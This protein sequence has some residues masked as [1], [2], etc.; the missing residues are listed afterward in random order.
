MAKILSES[1]KE[2]IDLKDSALR[3][4]PPMVDPVGELEGIHRSEG[5]VDFVYGKAGEK[6]RRAG[7]N[8]S[9]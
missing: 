1:W 3:G 7:R 9:I 4:A 2:F 6:S 8:S 5:L